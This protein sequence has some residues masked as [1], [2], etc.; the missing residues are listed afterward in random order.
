MSIDPGVAEMDRMRPQLEET[1]LPESLGEFVRECTA[2]HGD[3]VLGNWFDEGE[4]LTYRQFDEYADRL[5]SS[6]VRLG[7]RKGTHVAVM[8]PN[9]PAFPI[10]WVAIGRIGAV[11]I[12]V[13][14]AYTADELHFV[15]SDSDSQFLVI[16]AGLIGAYEAIENRPPLM[17]DARVI[18]HG[19]RIE[20]RPQ[21]RALLDEG[22]VPFEPPSAVSRT[23]LLNI[24][25][26][27][28]TTGFP[29]GCMLTHDY[30][31][32]IGHYAATFRDQWGGVKNSLIWAPFFY[33]DPMWQFLMIMRLGGTAHVARRISLTRFY[34]WLKDY[35]INYCIFPEPALK[36]RPASPADRELHLKYVSIYGWS[37]EARREVQERFGVVAREGYGMTEIG[38]ATLVPA[39]AEA[40][41]LERTCGLPAPFRRLR[42]V[43]ENGNDVPDGESGE[44]WVSG[45][46]ILWGYYKRPEA[47]ADS[48]RGQWFRTGDV[49]RRDEDGYYYIIGRIKDMI[50][51]SGENIAAQE[52]EAVLRLLPEVEEA[53]VVP[54]PDPMRSEEVKAYLLLKPGVAQDACPP[55]TVF[56]HC[57]AHLAAFKIPR[58]I[59]YVD[60]F[61][62]TPSRKIKKRVLIEE[63]EDLRAGAYDRQQE[64]W[65]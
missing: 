47:N 23:D 15:L 37:R 59:A 33:M 14:A 63:A 32:I 61:P 65:L 35:E 26:T 31:V 7:V 36:A 21:W 3:K 28:G 29:K 51:R 56:E 25:Y 2:A 64:M 16:D 24:Q 42:I 27:S 4:T 55:E 44:L 5:A 30:W 19:D 6:L 11:M 62:R 58:F 22:T 1:I 50:K 8:L 18:V 57:K 52:V 9:V 48:F 20:G 17:D 34:D 54:V 40:K 49:F 60:D 39:G 45:R 12:P 43:D 10:T 53:A 46:S 38:G 41:A 13:N